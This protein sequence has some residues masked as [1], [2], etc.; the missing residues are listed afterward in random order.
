MVEFMVHIYE[1]YKIDYSMA[2]VMEML[3]GEKVMSLDSSEGAIGYICSMG[4]NNCQLTLIDRIGQ[5]FISHH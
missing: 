2:F 3:E 1:K 5:N 4:G